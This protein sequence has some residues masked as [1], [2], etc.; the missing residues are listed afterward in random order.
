MNAAWTVLRSVAHRRRTV[1]A[2]LAGWSVVEAVPAY[3]SGLLVATALDEGFLAGRTLHGLG[4]LGVL[5]AAVVVGAFGTQQTF[6]RLA[7]LVEPFR[8]E[9]TELCVTGS[10]RRSTVAGEPADTA[11]AARLTSQ[12]EVVR[13]SFASVLMV[14]QSFLVTT[15]S[16]VLGLLALAPLALVLVLPPLLVGLALFAA[17]LAAMAAAQRRAVLADEALAEAVGTVAGGLRDIVACGGEE[18]IEAETGR[19]VA[20]Q[21]AAAAALARLTAVRTI[22][23]GVGGRLPIVLLLLG[24][25][26][27]LDRGATTGTVLGALTYVT[28]G[29]QPALQTLVR[30]VGDSALW[31]LVTLGRILETAPDPAPPRREATRSSAGH[32]L[33]LRGVTFGY[34]ARAEPIVEDLNLDVPEGEHLAVVGPSGI[35]KSTLANLVAGLLEPQ[36]GHVTLG[37]VPL[38][39]WDPATLARHRVLIPQ[40]AY[41]F[42]GTL[43]ENLAY[44]QPD[45]EPAEWAD[46]VAALGADTLVGRLGGYGAEID[47]AALSA[48]ERQLVTLLRA[49]LSP[50]RLVLLDEATC[51]LDPAAEARVEAA[52]AAR[53]GSMI[54]IAHRISSALRADRILVLDGTRARLGT[55]RELLV[56][57]PLYRDLAGLWSAGTAAAGNGHRP[58]G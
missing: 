54:V 37:G 16:A 58:P 43:A 52:F 29:L 11:G 6:R 13:E 55:H 31:L 57:S 20:A 26:W 56:D 38:A 25:P 12:V 15:T 36:Q 50:A 47:P 30:G 27:L 19:V 17:S 39:Q 1:L 24:T 44:L 10:L 32:H 3:L 48:G 33:E 46:A 49:Y 45:P 18:H 21:A 9:L 41:V 2:S 28:L 23:V 22:A 53:P 5:A 51:H 8:D 14:T 35:G 4:W 40:Q 34:A 7:D 42:A